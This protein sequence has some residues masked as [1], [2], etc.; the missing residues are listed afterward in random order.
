MNPFVLQVRELIEQQGTTA[1]VALALE[2]LQHEKVEHVLDPQ[3]AWFLRRCQALY[4]E[5]Q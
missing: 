4:E 5:N 3:R 1:F 2:E